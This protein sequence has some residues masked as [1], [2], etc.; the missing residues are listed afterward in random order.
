[1]NGSDRRGDK[2]FDEIQQHIGKTGTV[3]DQKATTLISQ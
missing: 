2:I 3:M 1:M